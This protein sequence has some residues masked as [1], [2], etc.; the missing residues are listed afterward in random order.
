MHPS[1]VILGTVTAYGVENF[2]VDYE[3]INNISIPIP[4]P[5]SKITIPWI[6]F[7]CL[8]YLDDRRNKEIYWISANY[9]FC[10]FPK[11][12]FLKFVNSKFNFNPTN[13]SNSSLCSQV[14]ITGGEEA[15][16]W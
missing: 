8:Y 9:P 7:N 2:C 14:V 10:F 5:I 1:I 3:I 13:L 12:S 4:I 11:G 15:S 16:L 6:I